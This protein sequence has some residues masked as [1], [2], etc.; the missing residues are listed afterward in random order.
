MKFLS[1]DGLLARIVRYIWNLFVLNICFILCCLPVITIGAAIS[2]M[3]AVF[4]NDF[5][6]SGVLRKFFGAFAEN[7]KQATVIWLIFMALAAVLAANCYYL[8]TYSLGGNGLLLAVAAVV[9]VLYLSV[10]SFAFALQAKYENSSLQ[11]MKN[12][13]ILSIGKFFSGVLMSFV[14]LFPVIM[15][16][17]DLDVFVNVVAIWIPLGFAL[18]IQI[19]ALIVRRVFRKLQPQNQKDQ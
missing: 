6:E 17:V 16:V 12:A 18:Q 11:T 3:Y 4:L 10:V 2:A 19:N 13:L 5:R 14:N 15:F 7:F 9:S 8:L 1:Y